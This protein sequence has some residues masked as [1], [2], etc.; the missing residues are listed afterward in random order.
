MLVYK[1]WD[2]LCSRG[3]PLS[4]AEEAQ[5]VM[6]ELKQLLRSSW[7]CSGCPFFCWLEHSYH[8][9]LRDELRQVSMLRQLWGLAQGSHRTQ[10]SF[11]AADS[12][13]ETRHVL[14]ALWCEFPPLFIYV[15]IGTVLGNTVDCPY[16]S[17]APPGGVVPG[18][19]GKRKENTGKLPKL[20]RT[21]ADLESDSILNCLHF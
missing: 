17:P 8:L 3:V 16:N 21:W 10:Q 20:M 6:S 1:R 19:K 5:R 11:V 13:Q 4:C 14:A 9:A 12:L 2:F 18:Y 15:C 7:R